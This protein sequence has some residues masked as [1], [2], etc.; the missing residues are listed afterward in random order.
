MPVKIRLIEGEELTI[1][2][3]MDEW[4]KAFQ[5]ALATGQVLRVEDEQ[6]GRVLTINPKSVAYYY[7]EEAR[8]DQQ[9]RVSPLQ[10]VPAG[11]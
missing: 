10:P 8:P 3:D 5:R 6:R 7:L 2:V 1:N 4:E 9:G 11:G